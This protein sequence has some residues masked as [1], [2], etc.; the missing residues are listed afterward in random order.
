MKSWKGQKEWLRTVPVV[1]HHQCSTVC[2][3]QT[4]WGVTL[5]SHSRQ[6]SGCRKWIV[7]RRK[8]GQ[9]SINFW[10]H[11]WPYPQ[12]ISTI[13][14]G[15][16][17]HPLLKVGHRHRFIWDCLFEISKQ[18]LI[19]CIDWYIDFRLSKS[20]HLCEQ[21]S[22]R[23]A[24][25]MRPRLHSTT[26]TFIC[27]P[28]SLTKSE[29]WFV[30]AWLV[31]CLLILSLGALWVAASLIQNYCTRT[32]NLAKWSKMIA[33]EPATSVSFPF[34][35]SLHLLAAVESFGRLHL[36]YMYYII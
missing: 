13:S 16:T 29:S 25:T 4:N 1:L 6:L 2:V 17:R 30:F 22:K 12:W 7:F 8:T 21:N 3:E 24:T 26:F 34:A 19:K 15:W 36:L 18:A 10:Q 11:L 31:S 20:G 9:S 14:Q 23:D 28:A 5:Y 27:K 32:F 33:L 35:F